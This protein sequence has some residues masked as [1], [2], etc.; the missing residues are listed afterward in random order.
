MIE[1][2][3]AQRKNNFAEHPGVLPDLDIVEARGASTHTHESRGS[4]RKSLELTRKSRER[5]HELREIT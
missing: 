2:L 5:T 4:S 1:G 3:Y